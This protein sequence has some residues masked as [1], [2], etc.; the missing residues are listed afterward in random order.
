MVAYIDGPSL[1]K[2]S[3]ERDLHALKPLAKAF[4]RRE[5]A[6][7]NGADVR[8]YIAERKAAGMSNATI[9]REL[10]LMSSAINWA[11]L[12][13]EWPLANPFQGRKQPIPAGRDRWLTSDE[14]DTLMEAAKGRPN[15]GHLP[16]YIRLALYTGMRPGGILEPGRPC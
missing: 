8:Q 12:E 16:D 2:R 7:I 3:H 15:A 10:G 11:R 1:E 13:L 9:N 6:T 14:A 4:M 5:L